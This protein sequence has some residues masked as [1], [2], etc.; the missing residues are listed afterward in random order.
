MSIRFL[1]GQVPWHHVQFHSRKVAREKTDL[2]GECHARFIVPV[3]CCRPSLD[4]V[5]SHVRDT[6]LHT[7]VKQ[8]RFRPKAT[9]DEACGRV[10]FG[11]C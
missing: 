3:A 5:K 10:W 8:N 7:G 4:E 11:N 1:K 2:L 6:V 9:T